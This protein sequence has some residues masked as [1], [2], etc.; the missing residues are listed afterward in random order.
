VRSGTAVSLD[1]L[2]AEWPFDLGVVFYRRS[3]TDRSLFGVTCGDDAYFFAA[4]R[5]VNEAIRPGRTACGFRVL[6]AALASGA[7]SVESITELEGNAAA[8]VVEAFEPGR[9]RLLGRWRT[10][11]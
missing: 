2:A 3:D 1:D 11:T 8:A 6:S 9:G 10:A 5:L 7:W 4:L